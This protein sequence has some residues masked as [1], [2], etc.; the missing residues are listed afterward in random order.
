[1]AEPAAGKTSTPGV[2]PAQPATSTSNTADSSGAKTKAQPT[3]PV[4]SPN[5]QQKP[6]ND[7]ATGKQP[8]ASS[9]SASTASTDAKTRVKPAETSA[10][11]STEASA[12]DQALRAQEEARRLQFAL[13]QQQVQ[14]YQAMTKQLEAQS[15]ITM[16]PSTTSSTT[17][18]TTSASMAGLAK[19][20]EDLQ[21]LRQEQ[22]ARLQQ[23]VQ[24]QAAMAAQAVQKRS[25][26][27]WMRNKLLLEQEHLRLLRLHEQQ[28][29]QNKGNTVTA[30]TATS[31]ADSL[32][33]QQQQVMKQQQMLREMLQKQQKQQQAQAQL[34]LQLQ[35]GDKKPVVTT[36]VK[37]DSA[38]DYAQKKRKLN[39]A[40]YTELEGL[41]R[42][43]IRVA[44]ARTDC[45]MR[46]ALDKMTSWLHRCTEITLLQI[47][48]R[49]YRDSMAHR[50]PIMIQQDRWPLDLQ[51][52]SEFITQKI[53]QLLGAFVLREKNKAAQQEAAAKAAAAA[54]AAV[55]TAAAATTAMTTTPAA[56][57]AK[58]SPSAAPASTTSAA[59]GTTAMTPT[60]T[61][62]TA[63]QGS[64]SSQAPA[65][66]IITPATAAGTTSAASV[67][68]TPST[69]TPEPPIILAPAVRVPVKRDIPTIEREYAELK[70]QLQAKQIETNQKAKAKRDAAKLEMAKA[71]GAASNSAILAASYKRPLQVE[72]PGSMKKPRMDFG[73]TSTPVASYRPP[74]TSVPPIS[75][76]V[77]QQFYDLDLST[78]T[79]T[80]PEDK[81]YLPPKLI[82]KIMYRAL[83]GDHKEETE[84]KGRTPSPAVSPAHSV[85]DLDSSDSISISDDAVTFMQE[86]VTEFL[87]YFTSE[88]RDLS[89]MQN[90]RTKKGV[91]LSISG[92]NVV[93]G[94]ENLGF[95]SYAR[96]LSGYNEKVKAS[97][98]AAARKKMER[99]KLIQQEA[100]KRATMAAN[101]ARASMGQNAAIGI[102]P[103]LPSPLV[104][105]NVGTSIAQASSTAT[106]TPVTAAAPKPPVTTI[107]PN[108][109]AK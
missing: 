4:L 3:V 60:N 6:Q 11:A 35:T 30:A 59:S 82:S 52:K 96:V 22:L 23:N 39:S 101:A 67:A 73:V 93:E 28:L 81:M 86:C 102:K 88:A 20:S 24:R 46:Q 103:V 47:A 92:N 57:S 72:I 21:K 90:R 42:V 51:V 56:S 85:Q 49:D 95:T 98:D 53:V 43:C 55:A 1:M 61:S 108:P 76:R 14:Q 38:A 27:E 64:S 15:G 9:S 70:A 40:F 31:I 13:A 78:R 66:K 48:Q 33:A 10:K 109:Q 107:T 63:G 36:T 71:V 17:N 87:L 74:T 94:M 34:K 29:M 12:M 100:M 54:S 37:A 77:A 8:V 32:L 104:R 97:Q 65:S 69:A 62:A 80:E 25:N 18:S 16:T 44:N 84:S 83:P 89:I 41:A 50:R 7:A 91:G 79:T 99:K 75:P 19:T 68:S 5:S 105:Y 45:E 106:T 58:T 26:E 2:T